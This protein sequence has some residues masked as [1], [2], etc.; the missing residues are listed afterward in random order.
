M[1]IF[2]V[3]VKRTSCSATLEYI[4]MKTE[5]IRFHSK[6]NN[7]IKVLLDTNFHHTQT[8]FSWTLNA[9]ELYTLILH[10]NIIIYLNYIIHISFHL[11]DI[12][13]FKRKSSVLQ[14]RIIVINKTHLKNETYSATFLF[15]FVNNKLQFSTRIRWKEW[16]TVSSKGA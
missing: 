14:M 11:L 1:N 7:K 13:Y 6:Q 12:Q 10:N 3:S 8:C 2:L 5:W 9:C 16:I 4:Q 15:W